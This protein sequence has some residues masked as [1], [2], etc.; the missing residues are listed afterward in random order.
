M[1]LFE[2]D[3]DYE[4]AVPEG[5]LI[6]HRFN[7][8]FHSLS[9]KSITLIAVP[10]L[11]WVGSITLGFINI[12][13]IVAS[14]AFYNSHFVYDKSTY[15]NVPGFDGK[16]KTDYDFRWLKRFGNP[17]SSLSNAQFNNILLAVAPNLVQNY[18]DFSKWTSPTDT[19][20]KPEILKSPKEFWNK[21]LA[22][23]G[24]RGVLVFIPLS[25]GETSPK[26]GETIAELIGWTKDSD[27]DVHGH[28]NIAVIEQ[29][30]QTDSLTIQ[31]DKYCQLAFVNPSVSIAIPNFCHQSNA[32]F[33]KDKLD[34]LNH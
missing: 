21:G 4:L 30:P 17:D 1:P 18:N 16:L 31:Y 33:L 24:T 23:I 10:A 2:K 11:L 14:P 9:K 25:P 6:A 12:A 13:N 8:I 29:P 32:M 7:T 5:T 19:S 15:V 20:V 34:E 3:Y 26:A 28:L 27:A 22:D